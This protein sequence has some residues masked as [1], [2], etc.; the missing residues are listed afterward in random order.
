M[1]IITQGRIILVCKIEVSLLD[2]FSS[3][4]VGNFTSI[5]K[6]LTIEIKG[7]RLDHLRLRF[8]VTGT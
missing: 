7:S 4:L 2:E 1:G 6:I 8:V 5:R 3:W